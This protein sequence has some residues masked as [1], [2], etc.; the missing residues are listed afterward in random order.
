MGYERELLALVYTIRKYYYMLLG[1]SIYLITDYQALVHLKGENNFK[2]RLNRWQIELQN[3][4]IVNI[5]H[6]P[7]DKNIIGFTK[8][9]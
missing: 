8:T 4:N 1:H 3:F 2:E 6:V 7:S 5:C 9:S